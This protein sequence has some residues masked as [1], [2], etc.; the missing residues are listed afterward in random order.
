MSD[1]AVLT[2]SQPIALQTGPPPELAGPAR[3]R[4]QDPHQAPNSRCVLMAPPPTKPA[5]LIQTD[6]ITGFQPS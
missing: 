1:G 4:P 5:D 6:E 3:S 2:P